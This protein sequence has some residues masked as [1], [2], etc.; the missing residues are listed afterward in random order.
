MRN[1]ELRDSWQQQPSSA[2]SPKH[3]GNSLGG[4]PTGTHTYSGQRYSQQNQNSIES[5]GPPKM[6]SG[7][8]DEQD[9]L[10]DEGMRHA[11]AGSYL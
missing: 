2:T 5:G 7:V 10:L 4:Q 6:S 11:N 3:Q 1:N 8:R 9:A